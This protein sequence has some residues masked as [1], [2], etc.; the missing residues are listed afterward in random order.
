MQV[1]DKYIYNNEEFTIWLIEEK[2]FHII[3]DRIGYC[4]EIDKN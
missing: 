1:G 3:N 4:I 2:F